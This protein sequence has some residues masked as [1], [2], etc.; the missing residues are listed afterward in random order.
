MASRK[1]EW[2]SRVKKEIWRKFPDL[3]AVEPRLSTRRL[4]PKG[5]KAAEGGQCLHTLTFRKRVRLDDGTSSTR[6]VQVVAD[7]EGRILK[8]VCSR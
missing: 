7:D 2:L 5:G 6:I 3:E 4:V 1:P 8:V